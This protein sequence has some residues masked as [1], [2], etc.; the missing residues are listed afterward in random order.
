L[1]ALGV[2]VSGAAGRGGTE[3]VVLSGTVVDGVEVV[4][5][6]DVD[7]GSVVE[8]VEVVGS[9]TG[10]VVVV[11]EVELVVDVVAGDGLPV[12]AAAGVAVNQ[13]VA[14][15]APAA[16]TAG[17][18]DRLRGRERPRLAAMCSG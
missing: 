5:V 7:V 4:E 9:D 8:V 6:V 10:G 12:S 3:V 1:A 11:D 15:R 17:Q 18:A 14:G 16:T 13:R 2:V